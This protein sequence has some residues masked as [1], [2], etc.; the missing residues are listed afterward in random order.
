LAMMVSS[1]ALSVVA[2]AA[3]CRMYGRRDARCPR[4]FS[5]WQS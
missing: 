1:V 2:L 5:F 3:G 4:F